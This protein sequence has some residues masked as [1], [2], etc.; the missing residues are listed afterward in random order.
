MINR[1]VFSAFL[2][3]SSLL[4]FWASTQGANPPFIRIQEIPGAQVRL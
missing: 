4:G 3:A 2:A 1:R